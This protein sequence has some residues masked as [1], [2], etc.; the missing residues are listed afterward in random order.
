MKE[1]LQWK[2]HRKNLK[3]IEERDRSDKR[4][5]KWSDRRPEKRRTGKSESFNRDFKKDKKHG[6]RDKKKYSR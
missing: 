5:A 1:E 3:A 2:L 6:F 4:H